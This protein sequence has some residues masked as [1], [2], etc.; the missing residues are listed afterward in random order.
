MQCHTSCP[1]PP[2]LLLGLLL[3][4]VF[5]ERQTNPDVLEG[6]RQH[7]ELLLGG[8]GDL[9]DKIITKQLEE[10]ESEDYDEKK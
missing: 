2:H 5:R 3:Q 4:F 6:Q 7:V 1:P 8:R 10:K 9:E